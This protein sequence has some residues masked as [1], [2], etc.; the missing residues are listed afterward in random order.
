M[1]GVIE[2]AAV[3]AAGT[4]DHLSD[5]LAER[6]EIENSR[7]DE[8]EVGNQERGGFRRAD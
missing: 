8:D 5:G 3:G 6:H 7:D 1:G 2:Q 4:G